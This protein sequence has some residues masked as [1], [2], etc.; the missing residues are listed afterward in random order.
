MSL[1]TYEGRSLPSVFSDIP[2]RNEVQEAR[3]R[4]G[5]MGMWVFLLFGAV[6]LAIAVA[7]AALYFYNQQRE[8]I[9]VLQEANGRLQADS[10]A[11]RGVTGLRDRILAERSDLL[12]VLEGRGRNLTQEQIRRGWQ[13]ATAACAGPPDALRCFRAEQGGSPESNEPSQTWPGLLN[14][15]T[16]VLQ[17]ELEFVAKAE[18]DA[19]AAQL[20]VGGPPTPQPICDPV[21]GVCRRPQ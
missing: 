2:S 3:R 8:D 18:H 17:Y 11:Y 19:R 6:V 13:A 20:S 16:T 10:A 9:V 21:T 1:T 5:R 7:I 4:I 12:E 15:T 14:Q